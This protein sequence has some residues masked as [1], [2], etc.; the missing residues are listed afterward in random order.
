MPDLINREQTRQLHLEEEKKRAL[1]LDRDDG[2]IGESDE[3]TLFSRAIDM[4]AAGS[5]LC[6]QNKFGRQR[7]SIKTAADVRSRL[8]L[9]INEPHYRKVAR[10]T[11]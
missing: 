5:E 7:L 6:R 9:Y 4:E 1:I 3:R 2:V 11:A 10:A 8:T